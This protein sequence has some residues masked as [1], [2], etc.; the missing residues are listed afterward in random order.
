[1]EHS[2][3]IKLVVWNYEETF[4]HPQQDPTYGKGPDPLIERKCLFLYLFP[5][6]P[7]SFM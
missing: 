4:I 5:S 3:E 2:N 1:M 7:K 6:Q